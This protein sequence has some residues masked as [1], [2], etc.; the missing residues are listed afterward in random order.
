MRLVMV[1]G[2][3]GSGLTFTYQTRHFGP[4]ADAVDLPGHPRGKP[5]PSVPAYAEWL[6]GYLWGKEYR[7]VVLVGHSMGG[8]IAQW[9]ALHYPEEVMGLVLIGTGAR[10]RVRPDILQL[11]QDAITDPERRREWLRAREEGLA[12]VAPDLRAILLR[13]YEEIGPA[14]QLNDF[15]CCDR[16][17]IMD[18]VGEI[19]VPTLV[20]VGAEDVMTPV[21][22]ADYLARHIPGA[23]EVVVQGATHAVTLEKPE[24]VNGAME[25][26]LRRLEKGRP[27]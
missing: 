9:Y 5:C 2:A 18:R 27:R 13:R 10:L 8:A 17:D 12:R 16:F 22:Y 20:I 21:K 25:A 6:R 11:C 1:H 3:G 15:L 7:D 4:L 19:R 26:F 14:V 23:E 24:E